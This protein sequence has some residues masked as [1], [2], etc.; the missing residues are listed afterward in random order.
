MK[1]IETFKEDLTDVVDDLETLVFVLEG[2]STSYEGKTISEIV[3]RFSSILK[4]ATE[5]FERLK[6]ASGDIVIEYSSEAETNF[7]T[8]K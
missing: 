6:Q 8:K 1:S 2:G 5:A 4:D 7:I 3:D